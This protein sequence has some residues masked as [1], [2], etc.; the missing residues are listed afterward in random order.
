MAS[1]VHATLQPAVLH[2]LWSSPLWADCRHET[3][4]SRPAPVA[5]SAFVGCCS[6]PDV[7]VLAVRWYL[8]L[9][10]SYRDAEELLAGRGI[11]VD[12]LTIDRWVQRFTP[13]LADAARPCRSDATEPRG[14]HG[15]V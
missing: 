6:P 2:L 5:R 11:Q 8:R 4:R 13:L 10:L 9:A 15:W 3:R 7:V 1:S 14:R 12:H